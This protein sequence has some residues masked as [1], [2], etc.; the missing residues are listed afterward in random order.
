[1]TATEACPRFKLSHYPAFPDSPSASAVVILPAC[2]WRI[3]PKPDE[4]REKEARRRQ[5][6][7]LARLDHQEASI[8]RSPTRSVPEHSSS[9]KTANESLGRSLSGGLLPEE[10]KVDDYLDGRGLR[11]LDHSTLKCTHTQQ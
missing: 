1:M 10:A 3:P 4:E 5:A 9:C 8:G 6:A 11:L 7:K 2:P